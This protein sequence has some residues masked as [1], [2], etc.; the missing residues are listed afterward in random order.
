MMCGKITGV[1]VFSRDS[2]K[3]PLA[4]SLVSVT[5]CYMSRI[6]IT[7]AGGEFLVMEVAD[8]GASEPIAGFSTEAMARQWLARNIPGVPVRGPV[9][10]D[11][12]P[13]PTD[14]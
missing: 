2:R 14:R 6:D 3:S 9:M 4:F 13:V 1:F 12:P 10:K 11:N 7:Q 5:G 8:N